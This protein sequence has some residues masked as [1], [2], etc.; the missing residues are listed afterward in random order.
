MASFRQRKKGG[1]WEYRIRYKDV[2][3]GKY[4]EIT[5]GGFKKRT[6][7][8]TAANDVELS[9]AD[10][11]V[12]NKDNPTFDSYMKK[13]FEF[14]K[15]SYRANSQIGKRSSINRI[16]KKIGKVRLKDVNTYVIQKYLDDS[17]DENYA[18]NTLSTD[19][20]TIQTVLQQ[21]VRDN[22]FKSFSFD[23]VR[24]P[25][26]IPTKAARFWSIA[27]LN[28][29]V[30]LQQLEIDNLSQKSSKY[31]LYRAIRNYAIFLTLAGC[32]PRISEL[33]ACPYNAFDPETN[34][35]KLHYNLVPKSGDLKDRSDYV[36]TDIMKSKNGKRE[37]P[38]PSI[39]A[40]AINKWLA[41][42]DDYLGMHRNAQTNDFLFPSPRSNKPLSRYEIND[43]L[44]SMCKK[45]KLPLINI[46]GFRHTYA[47][48]LLQSNVSAKQAQILLGHGNIQTTL[49]IYT[50][51]SMDSKRDAV[52]RLDNLLN[53]G[54]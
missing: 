46:H 43:S 29:Y 49:N 32:G 5:K 54:K 27:D 30:E 1:A 14:S 47:S 6:D 18:H 21:A 31:N 10:G 41:V 13:W 15:S 8:V 3:T 23:G 40:N 4:K 51:V 28:Q 9:L 16:S 7:A 53:E 52:E 34:I 38:V 19:Y 35:L 48:F 11:Y 37:V 45:F 42:R 36:R 2:Y 25:K 22:Y 17:A 50:H 33:L 44:K 20:S 39:T 26:A 12:Q 24:I